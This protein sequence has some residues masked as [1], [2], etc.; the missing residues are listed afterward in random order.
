MKGF[1]DETIIEIPCPNCKTKFKKTVSELK[2]PGVKCPQCS[3]LFET[4]QFRQELDKAE[5]SIEDFKKSLKSIKIDI[6]I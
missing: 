4:S 1:F 5:R 2:K 6:N 3:A